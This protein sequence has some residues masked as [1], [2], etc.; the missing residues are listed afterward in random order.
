MAQHHSKR[1]PETRAARP[2]KST[3]VSIRVEPGQLATIDAAAEALGRNR[4]AFMLET[5]VRAAEDVLLDKRLFAVDDATYQR[6]VA[7]LDAPPAAN[8]KLRALLH[9]KAPWEG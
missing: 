8:P 6:F 5:A 7:R 4:T 9:G 3:Q 1:P 2:A